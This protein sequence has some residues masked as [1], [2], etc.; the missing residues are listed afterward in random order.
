MMNE[1]VLF[2]SFFRCSHYGRNVDLLSFIINIFTVRVFRGFWDI[3]SRKLF[4]YNHFDLSEVVRVLL[5]K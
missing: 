4:I 1:L 2:K 5:F 3:F